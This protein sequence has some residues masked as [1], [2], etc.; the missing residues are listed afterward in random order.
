MDRKQLAEVLGALEV[1]EELLA[2][3]NHVQ[4]KRTA[5]VVA[6]MVW[7]YLASRRGGIPGGARAARGRRSSGKTEPPMK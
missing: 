1:I 5:R 4:A 2:A 6:R 7:Q 3:G